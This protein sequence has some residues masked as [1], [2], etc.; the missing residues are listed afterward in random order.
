MMHFSFH[1]LQPGCNWMNRTFLSSRDGVHA[2]G[3]G[4]NVT[5][6]PNYKGRKNI[7]RA[8]VDLM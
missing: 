3:E 6:G 7:E 5:Y 2:E 1:S 8:R 4:Y